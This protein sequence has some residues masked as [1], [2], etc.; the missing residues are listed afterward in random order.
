MRILAAQTCIPADVV[1][2]GTVCA[3]GGVFEALAAGIL[4]GH[5]SKDVVVLVVA[6]VQ[7]AGHLALRAV[8]IGI[9]GV[10]LFAREVLLALR[11]GFVAL[12]ALLGCIVLVEAGA[13]VRHAVRV[14]REVGLKL[15]V[16]R[17]AVADS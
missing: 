4:A 17:L 9:V 2:E 5:A 7:V 13:A 10:A 1:L 8:E 15:E 11:A 12:L 16:V 3:L 14:V 6:D